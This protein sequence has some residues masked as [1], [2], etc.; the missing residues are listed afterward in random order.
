MLLYSFFLVCNIKNISIWQSC[1]LRQ[2][3][4]LP[5]SMTMV[6]INKNLARRHRISKKK[7][8]HAFVWKGIIWFLIHQIKFGEYLFA[9][10]MCLLIINALT[11]KILRYV[12]NNMMQYFVY[13]ISKQF[14]NSFVTSRGFVYHVHCT[15]NIII[16]ILQGRSFVWCI[17]KTV[18]VV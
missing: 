6:S 8:S 15:Q 11:T 13:F 4:L 1:S 16:V 18:A 7:L 12:W 14:E 10:S 3:C 9:F 2:A 17:C 5:R